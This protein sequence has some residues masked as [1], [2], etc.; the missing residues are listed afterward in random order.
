VLQLRIIVGVRSLC[1][2]GVQGVQGKTHVEIHIGTVR[3]VRTVRMSGGIDENH[4]RGLITVC[5][6]CAGCAG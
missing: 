6:G 2:Q 4:S 1:V 3:Y 5:A